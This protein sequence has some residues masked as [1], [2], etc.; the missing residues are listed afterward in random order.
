MDAE[1]R[2]IWENDGGIILE[3]EKIQNKDSDS[4]K[5]WKALHQAFD[6][7]NEHLFD[8]KLD[9]N[10]VILNCSRSNRALGFF[11][12]SG[13]G[14]SKTDIPSKA[15]ISLNPDHMGERGIDRIYSTLVHEMCHF[16]QDCFGNP[17]KTKAYHNREW[18]EKMLEVGL[19]P[20]STSNS[21][22]MT[23]VNCSHTIIKDGHFDAVMKLMSEELRLPFMGLPVSRNKE[24]T[25]YCKFVCP[26][27]GQIARAKPSAALSCASCSLEESELSAGLVIME[28]CGR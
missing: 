23:G 15:E 11:M 5:M 28:N 25:G 6:F 2:N 24:K 18:A 21:S 16:W 22:K 10:K 4:M 8:G 17:P 13:W 26:Q 9:R 14:S 19:K 12:P 3:D 27:C 20:F 7:F 1:Q